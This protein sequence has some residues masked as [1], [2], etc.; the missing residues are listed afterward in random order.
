[1]SQENVELVLGIYQAP[2]VNY[3]PL[4]RDDGLWA[5]QSETPCALH[6]RGL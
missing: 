1:V 6:P 5:E 4:F 2:D 3:V